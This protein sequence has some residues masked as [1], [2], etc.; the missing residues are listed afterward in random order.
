M[1]QRRIRDQNRRC[2][3]GSKKWSAVY[4]AGFAT[5]VIWSG[6]LG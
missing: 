2:P 6:L 1:T 3:G 4:F 5:T